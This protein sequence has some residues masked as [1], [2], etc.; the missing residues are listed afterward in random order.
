MFFFF[1]RVPALL[2][3]DFKVSLDW[4]AFRLNFM[5]Q[6]GSHGNHKH[7]VEPLST[8]IFLVKCFRVNFRPLG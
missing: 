8:A 4:L 1:P 2:S 7:S 6:I 3:F 5:W